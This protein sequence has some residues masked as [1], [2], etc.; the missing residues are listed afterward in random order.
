MS[1]R[2]RLALVLLGCTVPTLGAAR[3]LTVWAVNEG[4]KIRPHELDHPARFHNSVW[5]GTVIRLT[6]A[7][8]ETIG[9]QVIVAAPEADLTVTGFAVRFQVPALNRAA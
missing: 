7:R 3:P 5:D 6:G 4:E 8:N 1:A 2:L 9:V